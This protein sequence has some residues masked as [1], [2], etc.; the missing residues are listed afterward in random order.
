MKYQLNNIEFLFPAEPNLAHF[1]EMCP[2]EPFSENAIA[3]LNALSIILKNETKTYNFPEIAT[4]A[5]FCRKANLL[6]LKKNYY[7]Q[8]DTRKGKGIV[9]HITPS[10][11]PVNFAYS[12]VSGILSGN[13]NIVRVPSIKFEQVEIICNAIYTLYSKP[14]FQSFC[15]RM[16]LIRYDKLSDATAYFSSICNARIIWGGDDSIREIQK[17]TLAPTALDVTFADKYSI[18]IINADNYI[19]EVSPLKIAQAFYNDTYLFDQNACT[20]P[21][22]IVWLGHDENVAEAKRVFWDNLYSLV[23]KRYYFQPHSAIDKLTAFYT[24]A[25][26]LEGIKKAAMPDNLIW[27]VELSALSEDVPNYRCNCGYFA[28]YKAASLSELADIGFSKRQTIAY[29]GIEKEDLIQFS[30]QKN[31]TAIDR[32]IPI[33]KTSEFSLTWDGYNL[34]DTLSKQIVYENKQILS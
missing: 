32:M 9:F 25:L 34:I 7:P 21:H 3:F 13:L 19:N 11:V 24:Q 8:N 28:E 12:L 30:A 16:L 10:N 29:Y 33:G 26:H 2:E 6:Q 15:Q 27:R 23:K 20:S 14:K 17:N 4:F 5:F 18:C 22:L 31:T 1:V